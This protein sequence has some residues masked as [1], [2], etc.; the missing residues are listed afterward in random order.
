MPQTRTDRPSHTRY[1]HATGGTTH[2]EILHAT[3]NAQGP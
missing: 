1:M 2:T 3:Q